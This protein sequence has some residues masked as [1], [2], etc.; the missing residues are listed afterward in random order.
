MSGRAAI[1]SAV[2]AL[3]G[4]AA[5]VVLRPGSAGT[6]R[7][8]GAVAA[9]A[10]LAV[11]DVERIELDRRGEK[12]L[13]FERRGQAWIQVEPFAHP[14]DGYSIRRLAVDAA[15][16]EAQ[17]R[18]EPGDVDRADLQLEGGGRA[19]LRL[20]RPAGELSLVLGR[21]GVAGRWYLATPADGAVYVAAGELYERAVEMDPREWRDRALLSL[22]LADIDAIEIDQGGQSLELSRQGRAWMILDPFRSR[23]DEMRINALLAALGRAKT[24]GFIA[25]E[26]DDLGPFGLAEPA[27]AVA[28]RGAAPGGGA[29]RLLVG[30]RMAVNA[31][32]RFGMIEGRPVVVRLPEALLRAIFV[33]PL[34][35]AA[36]TG[37][38]VPAADVKAVVVRGPQGELR[39]ERDLERWVMPGRGGAEADAQQVGGLLQ[40][41]TAQRAG[42]VRVDPSRRFPAS[43]TLHGFDGKPRD[44]VRV[45]RDGDGRLVLENGDGILRV[46]PADAAAP[47][48][49]AEA[50]LSA[51]RDE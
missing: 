4:V 19:T 25:D 1:V 47:W 3:L 37:S 16:V 34:D 21:R 48:A 15:Q 27:A 45:D 14:M 40:L 11:D 2:L 35:L 42:E 31:E 20:K 51:R 49:W 6:A 18:L 29:E 12:R 38:G 5:A 43:V 26:P 50:Q 9:A 10:G 36:P 32:D 28:L 13:A 23:A 22:D 30:D 8:A 7:S 17:Q 39:L 44:T 41:L 46:F 33:A 24:G